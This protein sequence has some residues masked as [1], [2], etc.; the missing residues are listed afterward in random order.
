MHGLEAELERAEEHAEEVTGCAGEE[1]EEG[2]GVGCVYCGVVSGAVGCIE[3]MRSG[4]DE[5]CCMRETIF[6]LAAKFRVRQKPSHLR[7]H[8]GSEV[9]TISGARGHIS[10]PPTFLLDK[11]SVM[12][13]TSDGS[14][15]LH[16][17]INDV[18]Q[19][20]IRPLD[21]AH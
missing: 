7:S 21:Q 17:L 8:L 3:G 1:E 5:S 13:L 18:D 19:E 12:L 2:G 9:T 15:Q 16:Q 6:G 14:R 10:H 20:V 4:Y 11:G